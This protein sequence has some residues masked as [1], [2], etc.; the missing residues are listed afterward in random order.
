MRL[1]SPKGKPLFTAYLTLIPQSLELAD[2]C[3]LDPSQGFPMSHATEHGNAEAQASI[4]P[5]RV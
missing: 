1:L 4:P 5:A 2:W 3:R